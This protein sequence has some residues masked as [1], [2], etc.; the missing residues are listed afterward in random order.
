[1]EVVESR[2][3]SSTLPASQK[4][5]VERKLDI[6]MNSPVGRTEVD[7]KLDSLEPSYYHSSSQRGSNMDYSHGKV[8][9]RSLG[10]SGGHSSA[11]GRIANTLDDPTLRLWEMEDW[12]SW[13]DLSR[14]LCSCTI[15]LVHALRWM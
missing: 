8:V 10:A 9:G 2:V 5:F 15:A 14:P 13:Y 6:S 7:K 4:E 11:R 12:N 1:M 3:E